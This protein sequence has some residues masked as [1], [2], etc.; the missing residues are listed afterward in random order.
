MSTPASSAERA[1]DPR[2][3]A[4]FLSDVERYSRA[5][6][7]PLRGHLVLVGHRAAGKS[8]L[9]EPVA[10][11]MQRPAIDLDAMVGPGLFARSPLEFRRAERAAFCSITRPSVIAAGGGFLSLH[12]DLLAGHTPVLVPVTFETYC[13]RLRA[14]STRP[15]L[16]PELS[17]QDE[18][19]SVFHEREA[20]HARVPT[21]PLAQLVAWVER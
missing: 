4:A 10:R 20:R 11:W 5:A 8:R 14:D 12:A 2:L 18:L 6:P 15:R 1:I 13:E 21:V 9:L 3:R 7:P 16:R 17:L 19:A